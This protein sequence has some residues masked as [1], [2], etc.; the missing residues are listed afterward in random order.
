MESQPEKWRYS[1]AIADQPKLRPL[2]EALERLH[3]R[4]L[5]VAMVVVAFH[6]RRV[7]P[8]MAWRRRLFEMRPD[9]P[10]DGVRM[11]AVALSDNEVLRRVKGT[12]D[13][14]SKS[15]VLFP[16]PMHPSWGYMTL[17]SHALL[18]PPRPSCSSP[19][20]RSL[21]CVRRSY[22]G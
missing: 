14:W 16:F 4:G 2:L 19:F 21:T 20:S 9:E 13:G 7:L 5:T 12:V 15:S 17:V 8:L 3:G 22:R 10:L 1:V 18:P 6:R 11:S